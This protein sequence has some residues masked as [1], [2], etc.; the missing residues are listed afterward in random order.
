MIDQQYDIGDKVKHKV[1]GE[2]IILNIDGWGDGAKL[3][4]EFSKKVSKMII[5]KYVKPA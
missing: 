4:I 1:F 5:A 2:G 3:T